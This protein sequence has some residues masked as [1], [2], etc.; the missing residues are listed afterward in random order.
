MSWISLKSHLVLDS[1]N[2]P[3]KVTGVGWKY[4]NLSVNGQNW[5]TCISSWTCPHTHKRNY[6]GCLDHLPVSI[7]KLW[8]D[9]LNLENDNRW[10]SS[11]KFSRLRWLYT[12]CISRVGF[13]IRYVTNLVL[14]ELRIRFLRTSTALPTWSSHCITLSNCLEVRVL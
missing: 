8:D 10:Y 4:R 14:S 13:M 11:M 6:L 5:I 2:V 9:N 3:G 12:A 1:I 7:F